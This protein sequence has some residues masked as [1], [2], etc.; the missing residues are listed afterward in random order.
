MPTDA[1]WVSRRSLSRTLRRGRWPT[2]RA[3]RASTRPALGL[4]GATPQEIL[5]AAD[6]RWGTSASDDVA[7]F[8]AAVAAAEDDGDLERAASL[9]A[10]VVDLGD[11]RGFFGLG[12][13]LLD[14][15]RPHEAY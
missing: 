3:V 15:G 13:T 5:H 1:R 2:T 10:R 4:Q 12:Y 8:H 14:L 11:V 6:R 7:A 9:W